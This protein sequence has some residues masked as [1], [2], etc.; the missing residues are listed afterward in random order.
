MEVIQ[1]RIERC[2]SEPRNAKDC[3]S[4]QKLRKRYGGTSLMV[5]YVKTL[6]PMQV[7]W[8]QS[9]V[10]EIRSGIAHREAQGGAGQ[11]EAWNGFSLRT[12]RRNQPY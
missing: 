7:V 10:M 4:H 5:Q 3:Q 6:F 11:E 12:S 1:V 8:V 2:I 9:L